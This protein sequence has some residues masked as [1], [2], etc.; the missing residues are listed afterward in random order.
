MADNTVIVNRYQLKD[1][2]G[3]GGM[4]KVYRAY[5]RLM[6]HDVALKQVTTPK[7][8]LDVVSRVPTG[9]NLDEVLANE[10]RVLA[11]LRHPHII[12]VLDYGFDVQKQPFFTMNLLENAQ[13]VHEAASD[14]S[15]QTQIGLLIQMLQTLQYLH[16]HGILHRDLKPGNVLVTDNHVYLLDF[17]LAL[18]SSFVQSHD[19][20]GTIPYMPPEVIA[21]KPVSAATDLYSFGVMAYEI[22]LGKHPFDTQSQG[23][24]IG[25]IL[26]QPAVVPEGVLDDALEAFLMRLLSKNPTERYASA[27]ET[28]QALSRATDY[29][30]PKETEAIRDSFIMAAPFVGR[31]SELQQMQQALDSMLDN[32]GSAWLI[33]GESGVGKSRLLDEMRTAAL[34]KGALVIRGQSI[35]EGGASYKLWRDILPHLI[36]GLSLE[37]DEVAILHQV[38]PNIENLIGRTL[39]DDFALDDMV[40]QN[41]LALVLV[42]VVLRVAAQRPLMLVLEDLQWADESLDILKQLIP[43][44]QQQQLLILA[45]FRNDETPHLANDLTGMQYISLKRMNEAEIRKLSTSMLGEV[46]ESPDVIELLERETEGNTFFIVEVVRALAEEAGQLANIGRVTIPAQVFAGGVQKVIERRLSLLPDWAYHTVQIAA[47]AGR[48]LDR[49]LIAYLAP[50]LDVDKWLQAGSD[51]AV[52]SVDGEIWSFSHDKLR[53]NLLDNLLNIEKQKYHALVAEAIEVCYHDVLEDY[54]E[55]LTKHFAIAQNLQKEAKYAAM[56]CEPTL[57][58]SARDALNY[59]RRAIKLEAHQQADNPTAELARLHYI[60]GRGYL[61]LS[62]YDNAEQ[63]LKTSHKTATEANHRLGMAQANNVLGELGMMVGNDTDAIPRVEASLKIFRELNDLNHIYYALTNL[64]ILNSQEGNMELTNQ[65]IMDAVEVISQANNPIALAQAYNN[66]AIIY[67]RKKDYKTAIEI[68]ERALTIRR[69]YKDR[70][71]TATSLVNLGSVKADLGDYDEAKR[72][73]D[74]GINLYRSIGNR[75][76]LARSLEMMGNVCQKFEKYDE[77]LSYYQESLAITEGI[78]AVHSLAMILMSLGD[79]HLIMSHVETAQ[80]IALRGIKTVQ[81]LNLLPDKVQAVFLWAKVAWEQKQVLKAVRWF[82]VVATHRDM[83]NQ[84]EKLDDIIEKA[85]DSLPEALFTKAFNAGQDL[86]VDEALK[87]ILAKEGNTDD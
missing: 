49:K 86:T 44:V 64:A 3:E 5:D 2:L 76:N 41:R 61:R 47:I 21:G 30:I 36:L 62:D 11:S 53:E 24:L 26:M 81:E 20:G 79:L 23:T 84:S 6:G 15:R 74:E 57:G 75:R 77:A 60:V 43:L 51:A 13:T 38:V 68:H 34:V 80:K 58:F 32:K 4:G 55:I 27:L 35:S 31:D 18:E 69:H 9:A 42:D 72:L 39:P 25:Q 67:D 73:L 1:E 45:N 46:G 52:F 70:P 54:A 40:L 66:L 65:Y 17:G 12:S 14:A 82:G 63:H 19:V 59:A 48:Q 29:P 78:G 28:I 16:R 37:D 87:K 10:F 83:L 33:G 50:E 8:Q 85:K 22:L 7:Q 71:G 56:A